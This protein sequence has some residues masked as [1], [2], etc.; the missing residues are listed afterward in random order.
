M[1]NNY[2]FGEE[3]FLKEIDPLKLFPFGQKGHYTIEGYNK[4]ATKIFDAINN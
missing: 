3:V 4:V 2:L 1:K